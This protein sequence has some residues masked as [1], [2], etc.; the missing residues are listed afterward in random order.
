M[1]YKLVNDRPVAFE[2]RYIKYNGMVYA[3]PTNDQ[4]IM[5]GYKPLITSEPP[6]EREGYYILD[7]Y[8]ETDTNIIQIWT[9]YSENSS[10][11]LES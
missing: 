8:T 11:V 6:E 3:N 7:S 10:E 9:E 2:G 1:L 5:A 4:L